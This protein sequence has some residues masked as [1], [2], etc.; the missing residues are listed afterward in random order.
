MSSCVVW[1]VRRAARILT[2]LYDEA[3]APCGLTSVQL[4]TLDALSD[5]GSC[6]LDQISDLNG[7]ERSAT[8]RGLQPLIRKGLVRQ[9]ERAGRAGRYELTPEG[10]E[11]LKAAIERWR[12][13]QT[14]VVAQA[15]ADVDRLIATVDKLE[16]ARR[17]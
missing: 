8:W 9:A 16:S 12:V 14:E 15:G 5:L 2:R 4:A 10:A 11:L 17:A 1:K 3:L 6:T 13:I 7:H